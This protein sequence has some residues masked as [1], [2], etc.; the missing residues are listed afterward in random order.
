MGTREQLEMNSIYDIADLIEDAKRNLLSFIVQAAIYGMLLFLS[1]L[2]IIFF[3]SYTLV[4]V[5]GVVLVC[6][7]I[8][9][10]KFIKRFAFAHYTSAC[11]E[12]ND[13]S[14]N[15]CKS[16]GLGIIQNDKRV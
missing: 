16:C 10:S 15:R 11:G 12:I 13:M 3:G 8:L 6:F 7:C 4:F 2:A 5:G 1:I 14:E 9:D